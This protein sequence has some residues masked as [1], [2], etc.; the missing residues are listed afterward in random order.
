M[1]ERTRYRTQARKELLNCPYGD[2]DAAI[3]ESLSQLYKDAALEA[4]IGR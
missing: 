2:N 4:Y 3:Q 1:A